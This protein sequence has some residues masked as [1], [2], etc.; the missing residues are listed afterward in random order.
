MNNEKI[1]DLHTHSKMSDGS[2]PPEELVLHASEKNVAAIAL[3][4]HDTFNGLDAAEKQAKI[5]G[6]EL[7]PGVEV[8]TSTESV[9]QI[10]I[11]GLYIDRHNKDML[12]TF[13]MMQVERERT[14]I[15]YL[16]TLALHGFPITQEEIDK[17]DPRGGIG[18]AHYAK[19]MMQH[20]WV[21]SVNE[22]FRKYLGV[23]MS[24]YI[25]RKDITPERAIELIHGAGGLA[26]MAHPHQTKL[27]YDEIFDLIKHLRD[28]GLDGIEGYY[29]EY[30]PEMH[31]I[32]MGMAEDL[33]IIVSGGSDFHA[34]M[35]PHIEIGSGISGN[36]HVPYSVLE[37]IKSKL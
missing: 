16:E 15:K 28:C 29:S 35:K 17:L 24:C 12:D 1:I 19:V 11:L 36:L 20:G 25:K 2:M 32:F 10:H 33:G 27:S 6:V 7:V 22:A 31:K 18:R 5:C 9:P 4:D 13:D 37:T 34:Q 30:T 3:T 14:H 26:F 21:S 8:S 23:G